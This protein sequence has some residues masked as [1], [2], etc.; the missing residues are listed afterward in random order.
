MDSF[1]ECRKKNKRGEKR[2]TR[3]IL[4]ICRRYRFSRH[5]PALYPRPCRL[6]Q[7]APKFSMCGN[8]KEVYADGF[9]ILHAARNNLHNCAGPVCCSCVFCGAHSL[10]S[11]SERRKF[12]FNHSCKSYTDY[13]R[14]NN[15]FRIFAILLMID[16]RFA[17][18]RARDYES[19]VNCIFH[20]E[21]Y[22]N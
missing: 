12:H 16:S 21:I 8:V 19:R 17:L 14:D 18:I 3:S 5:S 7:R 13:S 10:T 22:Y 4:A 20:S 11:R 9:A 1:K 15:T 2:A 6:R